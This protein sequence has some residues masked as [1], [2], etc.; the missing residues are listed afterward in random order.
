MVIN[1]RRLKIF[2]GMALRKI[3]IWAEE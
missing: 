2:L 1:V 3:E